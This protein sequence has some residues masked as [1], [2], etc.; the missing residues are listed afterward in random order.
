M[1]A[2]AATALRTRGSAVR[3][4][5]ALFFALLSLVSIVVMPGVMHLRVFSIETHG[6][7]VSIFLMAAA[8]G[9]LVVEVVA[10][11]RIH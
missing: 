5:L 11:H 2:A 1:R 4:P 9:C 7:V 8:A 6:W 10:R 3:L